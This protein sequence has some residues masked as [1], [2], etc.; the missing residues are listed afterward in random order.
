MRGE[1]KRPSSGVWSG[2]ET[3]GPPLEMYRVGTPRQ[4]N[5]VGYWLKDRPLPAAGYRPRV[6]NRAA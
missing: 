2:A 4:L 6:R 5:G 3:P 1:Q